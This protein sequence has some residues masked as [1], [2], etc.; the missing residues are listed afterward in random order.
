MIQSDGWLGVPMGAARDGRFVVSDALS[1][2]EDVIL[3]CQGFSSAD[4]RD[5]FIDLVI[6]E[7]ESARVALHTSSSTC[8][9]CGIP[10]ECV[11][12]D[13]LHRPVAPSRSRTRCVR[14]RPVP[15]KR[16]PQ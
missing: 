8:V 16:G 6:Q 4:R 5:A 10:V 14:A 1:A 2:A 9:S 11:D 15:L 7:L 3:E 12:G 13:W